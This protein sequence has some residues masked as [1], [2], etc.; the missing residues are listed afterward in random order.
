MEEVDLDVCVAKARQNLKAG[1]SP[2]DGLKHEEIEAAQTQFSTFIDERDAGGFLTSSTHR[3]HNLDTPRPYLHLMSSLHPN[4]RGVYG[5]FWDQTG[6][7]F[8]CLDSVLAGAVTSHCDTSYV[9]TCPADTDYRAFYI[10]EATLRGSY[11]NAE[12]HNVDIWFLLPQPGRG[13]EDYRNYECRQGLGEITISAESRGISGSVHSFVAHDDPVEIWT[14]KLK[15]MTKRTRKLILFTRLNWG[16]RSYPAYY[17]DMRVVCNGVFDRKLN[18]IAAF[19]HDQNNKLLRS[20]LLMSDTPVAGYDL[21]REEFDGAGV[22]REFPKAVIAGNC[23]NSFGRA[24]YAGMVGVLQQKINLGPDKEKVIHILLGAASK[25][26]TEAKKQRTSWYHKYFNKNGVDRGLRKIRKTWSDRCKANLVRTDDAETDRFFNVWS[27]YQASSQVRFTRALDMVGYRDVLQDMMGVCDFDPA[28]VRQELLTALSYQLPNGR[29]IRQYCKFEGAS[30]DLR[31]Y[32]DSPVWIADTLIT[33]LKETGDFRI[34]GEKV[35]FFD[36][37]KQTVDTRKAQTVYEHAMLAIKSCYDFRGQK[38]LCCVGY[39]DWNDSLDGIG[40]G[41][42]GVSAWLTMAVIYA[43]GLMKSLAIHLGNKEDVK[44]LEDIRNTLTQAVNH[45]A[46]DGEH[47]MYGFD[48][49]GEPIGSAKNLEG[50]IHLNIN[51]W[52]ILTGVATAGGDRRLALTLKAIERLNTPLGHLLLK[53]SYTYISRNVG[54]IADILPGLF[55]NGA[56]Y[57]HG[58]SFVCAALLALGKG[59]EAWET[60]KRTM[61][62]RTL[63]AISTMAP[64]QQSNFTVGV[65]HEDYGK[66]YYSNFTGSLNWYRKNL[67]NMFGVMADFDGLR[68][69][70][71]VPTWLKRYKVR[72]RFHDCYYHVRVDNNAGVCT[73][74]RSILVDGASL[75][76]NLVSPSS[77]KSCRIDVIMGK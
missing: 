6:R 52:A 65:D 7:G 41:G 73:G 67:I 60:I 66:N 24:P 26:P 54:R 27:K 29:A 35:G 31:M 36:M 49:R 21:S 68:I 43:A 13:N 50:K 69:D 42:R 48:D 19:N 15:N 30:H 34:L 2:L 75:K 3:I 9:P 58:Q 1:K 25:D 46:W 18:A 33:Y 57:T 20:G 10:C 47:Y 44:Y 72:K 70:P 5:S 22:F 23:R 28:Y 77:K 37:D 4:G 39:G 45:D 64:H 51:S 32:M 17:F 53:P 61:P 55:E 8:S 11:R 16:L 71:C 59:D 63:P 12:G 40:R 76:G 62:S 38:G 74:V 14:I 56:I